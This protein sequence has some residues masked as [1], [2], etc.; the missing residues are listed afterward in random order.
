MK[1][2]VGG[3]RKEGEIRKGRGETEGLVSHVPK[4]A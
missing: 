2:T 3:R 4:S 1:E